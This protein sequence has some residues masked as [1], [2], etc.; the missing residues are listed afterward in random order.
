MVFCPR[1]DA[2]KN[3]VPKFNKLTAE[4]KQSL[5]K[6]HGVPVY[7]SMDSLKSNNG[8]RFKKYDFVVRKDGNV[9]TLKTKIVT[10]KITGTLIDEKSLAIFTINKV[11]IPN[12][13]FKTAPANSSA[14]VPASKAD[15][16]YEANI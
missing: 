13:L 14:S 3:F 8:V 11:L 4:G 12:E 9:V 7:Q 1:D 16:E 6:Y 5:L 15:A 10:A 2:M